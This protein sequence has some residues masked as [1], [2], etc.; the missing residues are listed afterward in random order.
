MSQSK[1][2]NAAEFS[3]NPKT[4]IPLFFIKDVINDASD[5]APSD[6]APSDFAPSDFTMIFTEILA[7]QI[8]RI[9]NSATRLAEIFDVIN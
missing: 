2:P 4:P 6:F 1:K 7:N 5:F 3:I 9:L 8:A